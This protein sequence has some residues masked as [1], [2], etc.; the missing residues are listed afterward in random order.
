MI[1]DNELKPTRHPG[2]ISEEPVTLKQV[3]SEKELFH[4]LVKELDLENKPALKP[5]VNEKG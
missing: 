2:G 3:L 4:Y 1:I 5:Q